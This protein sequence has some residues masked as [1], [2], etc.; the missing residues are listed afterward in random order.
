MSDTTL[1]T[2]LFALAL[3]FG[4]MMFFQFEGHVP[5]F[6]MFFGAW[7][8]VMHVSYMKKERLRKKVMAEIRELVPRCDR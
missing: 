6:V 5:Y 2:A 3:P 8:L 1:Q 4:I 7:S